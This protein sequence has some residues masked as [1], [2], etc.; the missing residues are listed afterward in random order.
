MHY[1]TRTFHCVLDAQPFK[2]ESLLLGNQ[3]PQ[4]PV[5]LALHG[6]LD[7]AISF[8]PISAY[9]DEYQLIALDLPGH[10]HSQH[11]AYGCDYSIWQSLPLLHQ[12]IE[13]IDAPVHLLGHSMGGNIAALY[14]AAL[15]EMVQSLILID[16]LGAL[17]TETE[18]T[19]QQLALGVKDALKPKAANKTYPT[20]ES[21]MSARLK[22]TPFFDAQSLAPIIERNMQQVTDGYQWRIDGRLRRASKVRFSEAQVQAMLADIHCPTLLIKASCS[23]INDKLFALRKGQ[24][25]QLEIQTIEGYHHLHYL[26]DTVSLVAEKIKPHLATFTRL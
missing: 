5:I 4:A 6:W 24:I 13:Q 18:K 21:A 2:L 9:L 14:A 12:V 26:A 15:P 16:A 7:N 10:G 23:F 3:Q 8:M 1:Q 11:L 20:L 19:S 17:V 22:I 25:K